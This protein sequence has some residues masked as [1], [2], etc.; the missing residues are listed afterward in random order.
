M[1]LLSAA[2][3]LLIF[4]PMLNGLILIYKGLFSNF[5]ITIIVFTV[6]I[7]LLIL[8]LTMRQLHASKAMTSIQPKLQELQRRYKGDRQKISQ[9]TMRLYKEHGVNPM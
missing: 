3:D 1:E 7:R 5:G 2:W 8:P 4:K 6:I 9:E